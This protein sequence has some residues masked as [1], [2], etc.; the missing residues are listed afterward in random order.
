MLPLSWQSL[1]EA[2]RHVRLDQTAIGLMI[3]AA[4]DSCGN[5]PPASGAASVEDPPATYVAKQIADKIA[6]VSRAHAGRQ[7]M[8]ARLIDKGLRSQ[9]MSALEPLGASP[10]GNRIFER[11][12]LHTALDTIAAEEAGTLHRQGASLVSAVAASG[13]QRAGFDT[14]VL[15]ESIKPTV[16]AAVD[17]G[18][19]WREAVVAMPLRDAL[20]DAQ[21]NV[22]ERWLLE[23]R[24]DQVTAE[25]KNLDEMVRILQ[26]EGDGIIALLTRLKALG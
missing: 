25:T 23:A 22:M 24:F 21:W 1:G 16:L 12:D 4:I 8:P 9:I 17:N 7:G 6:Q 20:T 19:S 26:L 18:S 5:Y 15:W 2:T 3:R 11:C 14:Q 10:P 13:E